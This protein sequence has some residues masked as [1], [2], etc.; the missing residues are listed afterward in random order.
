MSFQISRPRQEQRQQYTLRVVTS[1]IICFANLNSKVF[2]FQCLALSCLI[3]NFDISS[4]TV[5]SLKLKPALRP[6]VS[7]LHLEKALLD[8]RH[9]LFISTGLCLVTVWKFTLS[10]FNLPTPNNHEGNVQVFEIFIWSI[11][12]LSYYRISLSSSVLW[13]SS[14]LSSVFCCFSVSRLTMTTQ[15]H[16]TTQR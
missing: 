4:S 5:V 3:L 7:F 6:V 13:C 12:R 14:I 16:K 8:R 1:S 2:D 9:F 15:T 10:V 11:S